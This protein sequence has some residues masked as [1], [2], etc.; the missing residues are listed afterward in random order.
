MN[1]L[2]SSVLFEIAQE[3]PKFIKFRDA[4]FTIPDTTLAEFSN[5][6]FR[7]HGEKTGDYW[8]RVLEN[9]SKETGP[10]LWYAAM[11]FRMRRNHHKLSLFD[12]IAYIFA[13][14][15]GYTLITT[16][17]DFRSLPGVKV[18]VK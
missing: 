2:D 15:Y 14:Q 7:T 10:G 18:I 6:M 17:N 4:A 11:K 1:C 9:V 5:V 3:N 13:Q 16:D 12:A 8:F